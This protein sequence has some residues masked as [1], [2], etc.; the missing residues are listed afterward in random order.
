MYVPGLM[1]DLKDIRRTL[2]DALARFAAMPTGRAWD[3]DLS[4][5]VD[6]HAK[7]MVLTSLEGKIQDVDAWL[8]DANWSDTETLALMAFVG[9]WQAELLTIERFKNV[10]PTEPCADLATLRVTG[11]PLPSLEIPKRGGD[12][13]A[14]PGLIDTSAADAAA[15]ANIKIVLPASGPIDG[16][17][18]EGE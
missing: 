18:L 1:E 6:P 7:A 2:A 13:P 11:R 12:P 10:Y 17:V 15:T 3:G 8:L 16:P 5:A 4:N 9:Q 14:T